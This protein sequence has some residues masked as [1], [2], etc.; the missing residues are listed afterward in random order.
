MFFYIKT[1]FIIGFHININCFN[2]LGSIN[3]LL[4]DFVL[5]LQYLA[6]R[7]NGYNNHFNHY[8][9]RKACTTDRHRCHTC[10]SW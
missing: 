1:R 9:N 3:H 5:C 4:A 2:V 6:V 10:S 8:G 7:H